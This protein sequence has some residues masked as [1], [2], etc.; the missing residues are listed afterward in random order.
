V[1]SLFQPDGKASP[2]M[3]FCIIEEICLGDVAQIG[4]VGHGCEGDAVRFL[5]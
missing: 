1:E 2:P 5:E 3:H 4:A